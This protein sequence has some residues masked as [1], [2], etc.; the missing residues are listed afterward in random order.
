MRTRCKI[1]RQKILDVAAQTFQELGFERASMD[2]IR[3]RVGG[4]KATLYNYFT[5]KDE[6]FASIIVAWFSRRLEFRADA[7]G[8]KLEGR[9]AM[10]AAL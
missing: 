8:A 1:K 10:I 9:D 5:N 2:A 6:I 7:G 3:A 4:S